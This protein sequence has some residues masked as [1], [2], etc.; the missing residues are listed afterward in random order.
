VVWKTSKAVYAVRP[1]RED[2][3]HRLVEASGQSVKK[4]LQELGIHRSVFYRWYDRYRQYGYNGLATARRAPK[5]FWNAV[6]PW[7]KQKIVEEALE[8]PEKSPREL[9][10]HMVDSRGY[11][12]SES[13]VYRIL[14]AHDLITSPAYIVLKA[15]EHFPK[16]TQAVN[17]L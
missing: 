2:G 14:K 10:W 9:A 17:E 15:H 8:H 3:D 13:T 5:Q 11:Y 6:P 4:A 12:V 16:P 1:R 7:E